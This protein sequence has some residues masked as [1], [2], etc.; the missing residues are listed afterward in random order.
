MCPTWLRVLMLHATEKYPLLTIRA[1]VS[2]DAFCS[3]EIKE[4]YGRTP[5]LPRNLRKGPRLAIDGNWKIDK[6]PSERQLRK[7]G[8]IP[9]DTI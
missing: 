2:A 6:V 1:R 5:M 8:A 4:L 7:N 9:A 3:Q